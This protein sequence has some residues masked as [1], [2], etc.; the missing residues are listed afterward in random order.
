MFADIARSM[1]AAG[2]ST[3]RTSWVEP[4]R[5]VLRRLEKKGVRLMPTLLRNEK[6]KR[7]F[8]S[9]RLPAWA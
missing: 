5:K 1:A 3:C 2:V 4:Y 7:I 8:L 6:N 9:R